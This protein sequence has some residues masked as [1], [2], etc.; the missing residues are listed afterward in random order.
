MKTRN[1]CPF[2]DVKKERIIYNSQ[3][4]FVMLSNPRLMPGHLLVIPKRHVERI[5]ELG[6][7]ERKELFDIAVK[8]QEKIIAHV[9]SGCDMRQHYRPFQKQDDLKINH[10]HIHLQP[11]EF[12]D[13]LYAKSQLHEKNIFKKITEQEIKKVLKKLMTRR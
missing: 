11:R 2:C 6:V 10:L 9:A 8:F 4:T 12:E 7:R 3:Y 5:A 13:E 1:F